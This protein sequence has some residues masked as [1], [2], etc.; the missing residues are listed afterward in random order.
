MLVILQDWDKW[1]ITRALCTL[2]CLPTKISSIVEVS[3]TPLADMVST[4]V[5]LKCLVVDAELD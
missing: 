2:H 1:T 4:E 3:V 5:G